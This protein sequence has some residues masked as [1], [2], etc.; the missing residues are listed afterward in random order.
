MIHTQQPFIDDE[1]VEHADLIKHWTD[2]E[3]KVLLQVETGYVY[4]EAIDLY[5]C[6]YTYE[7]IDKPKE[8]E[9]D[10]ENEQD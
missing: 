9:E 1:G 4:G 2:D 3:N 6:P 10:E 8:D 7:E 5:P